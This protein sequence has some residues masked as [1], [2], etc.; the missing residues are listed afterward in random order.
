MAIISNA[1][2]DEKSSEYYISNEIFCLN[3]EKELA[4]IGFKDIMGKYNAWSY[5]VTAKFKDAFKRIHVKYTK[6]TYT[7]GNLLLSAKS[8]NLSYNVEWEV[9]VRTDVSNFKVRQRK[10]TDFVLISLGKWHTFFNQQK[11]VINIPNYRT[12]RVVNLVHKTMNPLF[13]SN[14]VFEIKCEDDKIISSLRSNKNHIHILN[15][16]IHELTD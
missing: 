12:N 11:Y 14:A 9:K 15:S 1:S 6:S 16:V 10:W 2:K 13:D 3:L 7:S 4:L 5:I 8:Q